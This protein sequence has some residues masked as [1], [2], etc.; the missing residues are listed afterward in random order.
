M[1]I[2][3]PSKAIAIIGA[4]P[5][6]ILAGVELLRAGYTNLTIIG[7]FEEA[8]CCTKFVDGV[9]ADVGTCYLHSGYFNTIKRLVKDYDIHIDYLESD[10]S[11][12]YSSDT[13]TEVQ[14]GLLE[15]WLNYLGLIYFLLHSFVWM[16]LK[17]SY[18][19]RYIY[20]CSFEKYLKRVG[21]GFMTNSFIFGPGGVAQGYGF[22]NDVSAYRLFRWFRPSIFI[23]PIMNKRKRGTGIIREGYATLFRRAYD[24]IPFH[25][26]QHASSVFPLSEDEVKVTLDSGQVRAFES[27]IVACPPHA[28]ETPLS[29]VISPENV[30]STFL[31][32]YLWTSAAAPSFSDRVYLLD[33]ISS[34]KADLI[35][36]YRI[37]GETDSA[38]YLYWGVGYSSGS[39]DDIELKSKI[40]E[41]A[42]AELELPVKDIHY[43]KVYDYNLRLSSAAIKAGL[44]RKIDR[45]Q[46]AGSIWY[47]GGMLSHWD[48]DSIHEFN[49]KLVDRFV[50]RENSSIKNLSRFYWRKLHYFVEEI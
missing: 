23:T 29:G 21:L 18:L 49:M 14:P 25:I 30:E 28:L 35:S 13:S 40:S 7:K 39:F 33:H 36:T 16:L 48:V 20:S 11:S 32:S 47:S 34:N 37:W 2:S 41:Q 38:S 31:F 45:L 10:A 17:D 8:Q 15:K 19:G 42:N 43:F 50:Y 3:N 26:N 24:S 9:T 5:A 6:G 1:E 44:H 27:V 22:L 46:G 4:G 12:V